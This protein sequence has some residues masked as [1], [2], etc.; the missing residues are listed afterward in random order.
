ME[1]DEVKEDDLE[2]EED[3]AEEGLRR[4]HCFLPRNK[5]FDQVANTPHPFTNEWELLDQLEGVAREAIDNDHDLNEH[6]TGD[7][8]DLTE[9]KKVVHALSGKAAVWATMGAGKM[10]TNIISKGLWLNFDKGIGPK[11]KEKNNKSYLLEF[12]TSQVLKLLHNEAI[13]EVT[14]AELHCINPLNVAAN[15]KGKQ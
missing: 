6:L 10:V 11:Y 13:E 9:D 5:L 2:E 3:G 7:L 8:V 15:C 14:E 4:N 1:E 12:G